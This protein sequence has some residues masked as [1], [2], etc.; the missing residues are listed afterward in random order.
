[1]RLIR[2]VCFFSGIAL[3]IVSLFGCHNLTTNE[4]QNIATTS[5]MQFQTSQT[6]VIGPPQVLQTIPQNGSMEVSV[7]VVIEIHFSTPMNQKAT[8]QAL[9]ISPVLTYDISWGKDGQFMFISPLLPLDYETFYM[10]NLSTEAES[11]NGLNIEKDCFFSFAS[12][13]TP[14]A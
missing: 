7:G 4:T 13:T 6:P 1:M 8:A 12:E 11:E 14:G 10:V 9:T 5:Q 3:I 2:I